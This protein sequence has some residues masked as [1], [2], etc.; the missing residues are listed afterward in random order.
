M[1]QNDARKLD[2]EQMNEIKNY[3]SKFKGDFSESIQIAYKDNSFRLKLLK[4]T[5]QNEGEVFFDYDYDGECV[6]FRKH[7]TG[8]VDLNKVNGLEEFF[9]AVD[10]IISATVHQDYMMVR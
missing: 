5:G 2:L 8:A 4:I 7:K 9:T 6:V 3:A 10:T 1:G